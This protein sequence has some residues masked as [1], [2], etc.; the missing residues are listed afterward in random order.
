MLDLIRAKQKKW[1]N[2][3]IDPY[4]EGQGSRQYESLAMIRHRAATELNN[5]S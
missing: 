4:Q 1:L 2:Q 5:M 3:S